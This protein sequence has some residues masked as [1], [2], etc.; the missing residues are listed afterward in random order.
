MVG[1]TGTCNISRGTNRV[2]GCTQAAV[3]AFA[4]WAWWG[5]VA[6][7]SCRGHRSHPH[8]DHRRY[9]RR[10]QWWCPHDS[11]RTGEN[12]D[13]D[14]DFIVLGTGYDVNVDRIEF[15]DPGLATRFGWTERPRSTATSNLRCLGCAPVGPA[16]AASF[17][18]L[19][20]FVAGSQYAIPKMTRRLAGGRLRR[21]N[22]GHAPT[23]SGQ[24]APVVP[25]TLGDR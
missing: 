25:L 7:G 9:R 10:P 21:P 1:T 8:Q 15:L 4:P 11:C 20:R 16:A 17:G 18:P 12:R 5:V 14:T 3:C 13:V 19:F 2:A 6:A 22:R 24:A 23:Y